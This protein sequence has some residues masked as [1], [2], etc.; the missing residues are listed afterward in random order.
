MAPCVQDF[1]ITENKYNILSYFKEFYIFDR[2][3]WK[4]S[5]Q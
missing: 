3:K 1:F 2:Q 4:K 5:E